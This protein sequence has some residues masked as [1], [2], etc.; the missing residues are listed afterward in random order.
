MA[1]T[2]SPF[3]QRTQAR[4]SSDTHTHMH[5]YIHWHTLTHSLFYFT[6][7]AGPVTAVCSVGDDGEHLVS[8][9]ADGSLKVWVSHTAQRGMQ[10]NARCL[11]VLSGHKAKRGKCKATCVAAAGGPLVV[12][13]GDDGFVRLWHAVTGACLREYNAESPVRSV[14]VIG[15]DLSIV[16]CGTSDGIVRD[17]IPCVSQL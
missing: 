13:G 16:A 11:R 9:G 4:T 10:T 15:D 7:N 1:F 12:S 8:A 6:D 2:P 5:T 3:L 17:P 14:A